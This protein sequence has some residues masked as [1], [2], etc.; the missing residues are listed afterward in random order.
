M[1]GHAVVV[2]VVFSYEFYCMSSTQFYL[3]VFVH[4]RCVFIFLVFS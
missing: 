2:L 4:F 1:I 3:C